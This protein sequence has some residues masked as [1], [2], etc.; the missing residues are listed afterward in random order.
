MACG[1]IR[2]VKVVLIVWLISTGSAYAQNKSVAI[3]MGSSLASFE[4]VFTSKNETVYVTSAASTICAITM[5][6]KA[7]GV[8]IVNST[9]Q[10][11]ENTLGHEVRCSI[12][13][14]TVVDFA[15]EQQWDSP[16]GDASHAQL[17]GTRGFDVTAGTYI[18]I[19]LVCDHVGGDAYQTS[20]VR[21]A[22]LTA[23]FVPY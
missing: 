13:T 6:P 4:A 10:V 8:V 11:N 14:D 22:A 12:T 19:R 18:T 16:G 9:I 7:D 5:I 2:L 15:Y 20:Q 1:N 23:I 3:P 21:D 17:A